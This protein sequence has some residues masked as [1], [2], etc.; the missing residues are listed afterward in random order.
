MALPNT[1][2]R[3]RFLSEPKPLQD[4]RGI[5][6]LFDQ[7]TSCG[8]FQQ[9]EYTHRNRFVNTFSRLNSHFFKPLSYTQ[10]F[11]SLHIR[12]TR[13]RFMTIHK[14]LSTT[15]LLSYSLSIGYN[16]R[17]FEFLLDRATCFQPIDSVNHMATG[18]FCIY[19]SPFTFLPVSFT[20]DPRTRGASRSPRKIIPPEN[21]NGQQ[22]SMSP[23]LQVPRPKVHGPSAAGSFLPPP[24]Q[25]LPLPR[26][27]VHQD[28]DNNHRLTPAYICIIA[29]PQFPTWAAIFSSQPIQCTN[30]VNLSIPSP[31]FFYDRRRFCSH[32]KKAAP[33]GAASDQCI[34]HRSMAVVTSRLIADDF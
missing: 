21:Q 17:D 27:D 19:D 10:A 1:F 3:F 25:E 29:D 5:T 14:A 28:K 6:Y 20:L 22:G 30:L 11:S 12:Q 26:A 32:P 15:D 16:Q 4:P 24:Q 18:P 8:N 13:C 7:F 2:N 33:E 23:G 34:V 9:L 31:V